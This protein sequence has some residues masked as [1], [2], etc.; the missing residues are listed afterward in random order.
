MTVAAAADMTFALKEITSGFE[1]ATG[2]HVVLSFG[3]T[4]MLAAQIRQGAPF[5]LFFAAD[6]SVIDTLAKE[7]F[8]A[9]DSVTPYARGAIVLAARADAGFKLT[10]LAGLLR[11]EARWVALPHPDHAPYGRAGKEAL[12][13]AGVWEGVKDKVV[14]GENVAQ[15]VKFIDAGDAGAGIIALAV[16]GSPRLS[17]VVIDP[18]LYKP[19]E[20]AAGIVKASKEYA[21]CREFLKYA[22]GP[23]GMEVLKKYGFGPPGTHGADR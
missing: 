18:S 22:A 13:A 20:Q 23:R 11:P 21:L 19:I 4:G 10:G 6:A 15:A 7:G 1:Q 3:S 8:V 16:A 14:Y 9:P 17:Y 12:I 2:A 5:D